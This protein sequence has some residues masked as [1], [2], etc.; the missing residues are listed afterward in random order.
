[1]RVLQLGKFYP[2]VKGGME[3]VLQLICERTAGHVHNRVLVA[4]DHATTVE[5]T[6]GGVDVVRLAA[7][8]KIGAVAVCPTLP[9]RLRRERAHII[10]IHEPNPMALLAYF[11]ARPV[12]TLV[13]WFH[14]EVI[15][16][17][18]RY[19][20]FY[21]PLLRFALQRAARVVVTSAALAASAPELRA[22][23]HKC[24]VIPL[25]IETQQSQSAAVARRVEAMRGQYGNH[26]VLFVGRLVPYKGVDVLIEA[27]RDVPG[28]ALLVGDGS[29]RRTLEARANALGI[30]DRVRF[31]GE[32]DDDELAALYR[33]CDVFVLPSVSRQE[34]FG[35]VQVEAM[36]AGKPVVSTALGTGVSWV[37]QNGKTG[38]VVP[39]RDADAL[40]EALARL[41]GD[42]S[43]RAA[44]GAAG[45]LRARSTFAVESMIDATITLYRELAGE[46]V[47]RK[48]VA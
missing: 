32:V 29:Q 44:M 39:P 26:I 19:R 3:K 24:V 48:T 20:I 13:I 14:S 17:S 36:A 35:V 2:P 21:R 34:A 37:N 45:A 40:R 12:G 18:W 8:A 47:G 1:M 6:V 11:L 27:M 7:L 41:I 25:G 9:W 5:E 15:R 10:V 16:P 28:V 33:A 46:N 38:L 31:L 30:S 23:Q 42:D 22:W 43:L 4:N